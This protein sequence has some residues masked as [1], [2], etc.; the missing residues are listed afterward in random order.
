MLATD[1]IYSKIPLTFEKP[2]DTGTKGLTKPDGTPAGELGSWETKEVPSGVFCARP[3]I[4]FPLNPTESQLKEVRA[5]GIGKK[6]LYEKWPLVV[7]AWAVHAK[8]CKL[9]GLQRFVGAKSAIHKSR[10]GY[11]RSPDYG[12]WVNHT[13]EVSFNPNPKRAGFGSNQRLLP[14]Q[15]FDWESEPYKP[16]IKSP[17]AIALMLAEQIALEQPDSEFLDVDYRE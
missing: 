1:G 14:W 9:V 13:I 2:V 4:Y 16:A 6:A 7:R 5:R 10:M 11:T 8:S 12:E 3:G 15:H 17:E